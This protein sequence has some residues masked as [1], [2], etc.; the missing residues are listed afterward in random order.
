M[1]VST[2]E[3]LSDIFRGGGNEKGVGGREV[4]LF[5]RCASVLSIESSSLNSTESMGEGK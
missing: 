3:Y 4:E 2:R 5:D 1:R